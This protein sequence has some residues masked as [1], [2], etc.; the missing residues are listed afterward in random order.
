MNKNLTDK[1]RHDFDR[2]AL[3]DVEKWDHNNHYHQFLLKQLPTQCQTILDIG[4]GVGEFS[5]LVASRADRVVAIDLS[6]TSIEIAEQRSPHSNN[7][8][9]QVADIQEWEFIP[10]YY[11][12]IASIATVHHLSLETLLPKLKLALKPGGVLVVLDLLDNNNIRG[13]FSDAIAVPLNWWFLKTKNRNIKTSLA[14]KEAMREHFRTDQYLNLSQVK[15][16]YTKFLST[17]KIRKHLF[18]RYS[19]VWYKPIADNS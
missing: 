11:D 4:C 5:R 2:L 13:L 16:I 17:P 3:Y 9:Y 15:N 14:E 1:I 6:P 12:A 18:W 19:V 10:E 8:N 7:I